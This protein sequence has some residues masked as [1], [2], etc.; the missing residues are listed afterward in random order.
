MEFLGNINLKNNNYTVCRC[1][2]K[3][4]NNEEKFIHFKILLK[5]KE[6]IKGKEYIISSSLIWKKIF[7]NKFNFKEDD[8]NLI[9]I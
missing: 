5:D 3:F 6:E 8:E 4:L 7:L 2:M 9:I 1:I